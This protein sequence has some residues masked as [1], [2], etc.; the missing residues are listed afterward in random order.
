MHL[1]FIFALERLQLSDLTCFQMR[2]VK[3]YLAIVNINR[4]S[5]GIVNHHDIIWINIITVHSKGIRIYDIL[6]VAVIKLTASKIII[7]F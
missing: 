6:I 5:Y 7:S 2:T 4:H 3:A 1:R